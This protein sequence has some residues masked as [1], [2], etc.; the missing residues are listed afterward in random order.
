MNSFQKIREYFPYVKE[1]IFLNHAGVSPLC[2]PVSEAI[3]NYLECRTLGKDEGFDLDSA[4]KIFAQLINAGSEEVALVPNTSTGLSIT[5]NLL[6]Y[7][8]N[9]NA[10]TTDLEFPSVVYPWLRIKMSSNLE[11]RYVKNINGSLQLEDFEKAVNDD[12]VAVILSHVEY[13]NGF[14]N[15]LKAIAEIAHDHGALIVVDACQSA[16]AMKIDVKRQDVDFLTTSCYK[17]L[18][19]PCGAGFLYVREDLI[20]NAEPIFV[21]W[22]SVKHEIFETVDLWNNTQ[23]IFSKTACR[24]EIGTPSLLSY[25]GA[26]AALKLILEC[27]IETIENRIIELTDHLI[28]RLEEDGFTVQTPRDSSN[29]SGIV[30]FKASKPKEKVEDLRRRGVI[31]SARMNGIR[32]SPHFYNTKDDLERFLGYVRKIKD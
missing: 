28:E 4:R 25:V 6:K 26:A 21:G 17:W 27:G 13:G 1:R 11:I 10:V 18:L 14:K 22:A 20:E 9:S 15:D 24:F 23:L 31:V 32:V 12:T 19:G 30:N 2:I 7:P 5:A 8:R 3:R 16:G 29:R